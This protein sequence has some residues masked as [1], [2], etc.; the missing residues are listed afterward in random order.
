M[1]AT[2]IRERF[3]SY[4]IEYYSRRFLLKK[5]SLSKLFKCFNFTYKFIMTNMKVNENTILIFTYPPKLV[6]VHVHII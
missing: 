4:Y 1:I 6:N 3:C 5:S 2:N